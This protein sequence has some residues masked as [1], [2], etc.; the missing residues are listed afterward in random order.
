WK[1]MMSKKDIYVENLKTVQRVMKKK[2]PLKKPSPAILEERL[3]AELARVVS[4]EE[5]VES[6][7]GGTSF[8]AVLN[9]SKKQKLYQVMV[10]SGD[11]YRALIKEFKG[12][13]KLKEK[14]K[15]RF[16]SAPPFQHGGEKDMDAL[17]NQLS[18]EK[19][20]KIGYENILKMLD[21]LGDK[22]KIS[23]AGVTVVPN[24]AKPLIKKL[25]A[26]EKEHILTLEEIIRSFGT[27]I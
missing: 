14:I 24:K 22:A 15:E 18:L 11:H 1:V 13:E 16:L 5:K 9:E 21:R 23:K 6:L 17:I 19:S 26:A 4:I 27:A 12:L 10:A 3:V 25:I 2:S 7:A 8:F 20:M